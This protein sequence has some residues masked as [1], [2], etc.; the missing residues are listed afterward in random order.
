MI[1][2]AL[3]TRL[4]SI[5]FLEL[6]FQFDELRL[7]ER[8]QRLLED[9]RSAF[10]QLV[11]NAREAFPFDL[12]VSTVNIENIIEKLSQVFQT[13]DAQ[14]RN[15]LQQS[16]RKLFYLL[17]ELINDDVKRCYPAIQ[18]F[19]SGVEVLGKVNVF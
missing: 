8:V 3:K 10:D 5:I 11:Q 17:A 15:D 14:R 16:A 1:Q 9:N 7:R 4:P 2:V 19:S 18:F 12:C 13:I 6:L